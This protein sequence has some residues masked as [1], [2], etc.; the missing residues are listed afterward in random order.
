DNGI[1]TRARVAHDVGASYKRLF[2]L[3]LEAEKT[4]KYGYV[5]QEK[6]IKRRHDLIRQ[7]RKWYYRMFDLSHELEGRFTLKD[8]FPT[9]YEFKRYLRD[10]E[11][12]EV[13]CV[14]QRYVTEESTEKD[15]E[16]GREIPIEYFDCFKT[17]EDCNHKDGRCRY[18]EGKKEH[19]NALARVQVIRNLF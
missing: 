19:G 7:A 1:L 3:Y 10:I 9:E 14:F 4:E 12:L 18:L 6:G 2:D 15:P 16:T 5:M 8:I 17:G 13:G 11:E